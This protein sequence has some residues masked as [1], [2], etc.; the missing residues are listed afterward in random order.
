M[1]I[2]WGYS[3]KTEKFIPLA[4]FPAD[5]YL[6]IVRQAIEN[7][8]W[9]LSHVSESGI[10]AYTPLSFQSYSEEISVRIQ[11]N[12]AV[13]K[14]E[15]VGIQLL[16]NDYG[17]NETNLEKLFHEFEYVQYH[18]Q[19]QWD[20]QVKSFHEYVA[21]Q[22]DNYFE[23]AP[24]AVKNKI[25]NI[26]YLFIPR[27]GYAATPI[28]L[29][30]NIFCFGAWILL[31]IAMPFYLVATQSP[32]P[33]I[34]AQK[35]LDTKLIGHIN[36]KLV[37]EGDYWRLI[38]YQF[39]HGSLRH[40]FFNMYAFVYLGLI[41]ENKIGWKKFLFI[42]LI[43]GV[44]GGLTSIA[45]H[46]N[47]YTVGASGAIM[48][49]FGATMALLLNQFFEKAA[50]KALLISTVLVLVIM[51]INGSISPI[52]DN[53]CHL[54][55]LASGFLITY[56]LVFDHQWRFKKI[57]PTI[58][59][60]SIA[61]IFG[62]FTYGVTTLT[63]LYQHDEFWKLKIEFDKN[64]RA[65]DQVLWMKASY[66]KIE[67]EQRVYQH[68][69]KPSK[70]NLEVTKKMARLKLNKKYTLDKNLKTK[71]AQETYE[72]AELLLKDVKSDHQYKRQ[73]SDKINNIIQMQV[74]FRDS[75]AHSKRPSFALD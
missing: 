19:D 34:M 48:G 3:P 14:S 23:K 13:V 29:L 62:T 61:A 21:Q 5:K 37:L 33:E 31:L 39:L 36:R 2:R 6:I 55:G 50:N 12:F 63:P 46:E 70:A 64:M 32:T 71:L 60:V 68:G 10:I 41:I 49:L 18:L 65:F 42:Y 11:N 28:L 4:D 74:K 73:V 75:L 59:Y 20:E 24:L 40:L 26:F 38:S 25:K 9:Q 52:V 43:S 53:A 66:S 57:S 44:C 35:V 15:C 72:A 17:K 16:F 22:D 45:H 7:L 27:K 67:K 30:L 47:I 58:K 56:M 51:L 69:I 54:G 8:G 1:S